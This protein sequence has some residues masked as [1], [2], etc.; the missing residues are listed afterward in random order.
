MRCRT[1]KGMKIHIFDDVPHIARKDIRRYECAISTYIKGKNGRYHVLLEHYKKGRKEFLKWQFLGIVRSVIRH[2]KSVLGKWYNTL[3]QVIHRSRCERLLS[4]LRKHSF[5]K[6]IR[7]S[8]YLRYIRKRIEENKKC[9]ECETIDLY[10][11]TGP[12][13]CNMCENWISKSCHNKVT[14]I[15]QCRHCS[16]SRRYNKVF[17]YNYPYKYD[18]I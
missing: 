6:L 8:Y 3:S 12:C 15:L 13:E 5:G 7:Q 9:P 1:Y 11:T 18:D 17:Q 10:K 2:R 16:Y 14:D 4:I